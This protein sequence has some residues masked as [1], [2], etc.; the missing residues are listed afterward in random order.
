[1]KCSKKQIYEVLNN[2]G[3]L[4]K[5][6]PVRRRTIGTMLDNGTFKKI[7]VEHGWRFVEIKELERMIKEQKK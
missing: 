5:G 2:A 4:Y 7:I 6:R 1:M 3:Y